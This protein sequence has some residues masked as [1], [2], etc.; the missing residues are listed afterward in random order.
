MKNFAFK[1]IVICLF[2]V[3]T[4]QYGQI[5]SYVGGGDL[6]NI[7]FNN[8][9]QIDYFLVEN[10]T[11][12]TIY[13]NI[14]IYPL[15]VNGQST[16]S[17]ITNLQ[18]FQNITS[19]KGKLYVGN[20]Q[21][22]TNFEGLNNLT[23]VGSLEIRNNIT[24]V[25]FEGLDNLSLI[26]YGLY[27]VN[28]NSFLKLE[29]NT[30]LASFE[31]LDSLTNLKGTFEIFSGCPNLSDFTGLE[32]LTEVDEI[33]F[34]SSGI[35]SFEGLDNLAHVNESMVIQNTSIENFVGLESLNTVEG[36]FTIR[37]NPQL[38]SLQGLSGLGEVGLLS[39]QNNNSLTTL[40]GINNLDNLHSLSI[41]SNPI[42]V[43]M[44]GFTSL[45]S[46]S[47]NFNI[48]TN[49][50]LTS[51]ATGTSLTS[52]G[53][54]IR[55]SNNPVLVNL[56][57]LSSVTSQNA[58]R[59]ENN[60]SLL[61]LAG[62]ENI[63]VIN[64]LIITS[65][66]N[67]ALC[68]LPNICTYLSNGGTATISGNADGCNSI[69]QIQANCNAPI[70]P[71]GN[72]SFT[73]QA[74]LNQ[75]ILN[76]PNCT[77]I[78]GNVFINGATIT[79]LSPLENITTITGNFTIHFCSNLLT[80]APL[81]NLTAVSGEV[82][83][84]T[85]IN[86]N[87]LN[88]LHNLTQVGGSL[89]V[90]SNNS[91]SDLQGL[92]GISA[93]NNNYIYIANNATLTSLNGLQNLNLDNVT[94]L[95]LQDNPNLSSCSFIPRIC[96]YLYNNGTA[97]ISGN[98]GECLNVIAV[99]NACPTI[100]NGT[101][102]SLN[103]P[104]ANRNTIIEADL[105][106][107]NDLF[108]KNII[109][110][111]G[112]FTVP[113][114]R[115]LSVNGAIINNGTTNDFIIESGGSLTQTNNLINEDAITVKRNSFPL[116]RQDYSMWSSPITGQNLRNFSPQTLFNR[117][118]SYNTSDGTVGEYVQELFTNQDIQI[119]VFENAKGYLIR[120]PNNWPEFVNEMTPGTS[121][122]GE[123]KGIPNNG[124]IS[125]EISTANTGLNLVGNPYPSPLFISSFFDGNPGIERTLYFWRKR[126]NSL[127]SGY[128][129]YTELGL[130]SA[131]PEL[132]GMDLQNTVNPG[133]GFFIK[134]NGQTT[135]NFTNAMRTTLQNG[136]F[137]KSTTIEK[138]RIWLNLSKNENVISQTLLGYVAGATQGIDS[139]LDGA[140]FN[141]SPTA[142]T[143]LIDNQE[144]AIQ[145]RNIPFDISDSVPL[146]FKT[147]EAGTYSISLFEFDGL[148]SG[149]QDIFLKDNFNGSL[150]NLKLA[151]YTF[152]SNEG[153]FN[154]RFEIQYQ[155]TLKTNNPERNASEVIIYKENGNL[156]INFGNM[157]MQKIEI[158]DLMGKI[159][160][161]HSEIKDTKTAIRILNQE[162]QMRLIK[163]TSNEGV[164][165]TKKLIL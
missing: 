135:L 148:F 118:S 95:Y 130:A 140:Y 108:T 86:L 98:T 30:S 16:A 75:F 102:W 84:S 143:S 158:I 18:G 54:E 78:T 50:A 101:N 132:A 97:T 79:D 156:H 110:N 1:L 22:L 100:W 52:I 71:E 157:Q 116:Y 27:Q 129:T 163:I 139:G 103:E 109:V 152:A 5:C 39:I 41:I 61:S 113:S 145:A 11:C 151:A 92:E 164:V 121:Y 90:V 29:G 42:L 58:L 73:S 6:P 34:T 85:L 125:I 160:E 154:Q 82:Y 37:L 48:N 99:V 127:G 144:F 3:S 89:S 80:L 81:E 19:I 60:D 4:K 136:I 55:V 59:I 20:N 38:M 8:Q 76:Y 72:V 33:L 17:D 43:S 13:A 138:H 26:N 12:T 31:G 62:L 115:N 56:A 104:D 133:Q 161:T 35:L 67:L 123:F 10:P 21:L 94:H 15:V 93:I 150:H 57:N 65:S 159:L 120:M 64:S 66:N 137:L 49:N 147:N 165:V 28:T 134:S 88:G 68:E 83:I 91:L 128:A 162:N 46:L 119:K 107:A 63:T 47:G 131:Q 25:N 44:A 23:Q 155:T 2:L 87:S 36:D 111:S 114:G 122:L 53:G 77:Q 9:A 45:T 96:N 51:I 24:L 7:I 124:N 69:V 106:L 142:L 74:L 153:N 126:N 105:T 32:S 14:L 141:D 149:N 40:S 112:V 117:F 146:N 70:C